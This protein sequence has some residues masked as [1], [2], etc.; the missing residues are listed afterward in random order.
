MAPDRQRT[1]RLL[2]LSPKGGSGK[3]GLSRLLMSAA[4][5]DGLRA[6]G[7]DADPQGTFAGWMSK[8]E[9]YRK[10][11]PEVPYAEVRVAAFADAARA[12]DE[13]AADLV[14]VDTPTA[15]ENDPVATKALILASDLVLI[16]CQPL[17]DDVRSVKTIML[18]VQELGRPAYFVLNKVKRT[19]KEAESSRRELG[20]VGPVIAASIPDSIQI[21]RAM[22]HGLG[23]VETNGTGAD[24]VSSVWAEAKRLLAM[25]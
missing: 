8:R 10:K 19:V 6:I 20:K 18:T 2:H 25:T 14:V 7:L 17:D 1:K 15:L 3:S 23:V 24:D 22:A 11:A 13:I 21:A 12:L 16:P 5:R 4:I 9:R